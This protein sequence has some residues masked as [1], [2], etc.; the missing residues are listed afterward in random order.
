[1]NYST[2][3]NTLKSNA[4]NRVNTAVY[5]ALKEGAEIEDKRATFY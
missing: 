2:Y 3:A 4:A 1:D 5:N